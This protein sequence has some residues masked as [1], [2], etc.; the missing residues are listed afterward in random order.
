MGRGIIRLQPTG[1]ECVRLNN[2][3]KPQK[4]GKPRNLVGNVERPWLYGQPLC[5]GGTLME[6]VIYRLDSSPD[7]A[8]HWRSSE[9]LAV[10]QGIVSA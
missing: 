9:A 8:G 10:L 4:I 3:G 2:L 1:T 6:C 5:L 7:K